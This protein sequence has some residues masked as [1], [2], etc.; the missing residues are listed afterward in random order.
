MEPHAIV[1]A[2]DGDRVEIDTPNQAIAMAQSAFAAFFGIPAQNVT[3]R[4]PFL[5]GGFGSKAILA[6][7]QILAILAARM[8]GRPVKLVLRRDQ[9]FGPVGHRGATRQR[10]RLAL[11]G[12]ARLTALEHAAEATTSSFDAFLE[13]AANA[14][15]NL[16]ASPAIV[17][18]HTGV[19]TDTGTPGPMRAPGEG[20]TLTLSGGNIIGDT[21]TIDGANPQTG[22]ALTDIF[23]SVTNNPDTNVLSGTLADNGGA[24]ATIALNEAASN[25]A[26][27]A[28]DDGLAPATDARGFSR[29]D[30]A[31]AANNGTNVSDLGAFEASHSLVVTTLADAVDATDGLLSLREALA[32][33]QQD[34]TTADTITF[35][36]AL[37]GGMI[38]LTN[39]ELAVDSDVAIDGDTDADNVADITISGNNT[40]RVFAVTG[41]D[42]TFDA[43]TI[44]YGGNTDFGG[45]VAVLSG[46]ALTI[47]NS[48]L[49]D[50]F[51]FNSGGGIANYTGG[52]LT[53]INSTLSSNQSSYDGGAI[54]NNGTAT[55]INTTLSEN[56]AGQ[57]GGGIFNGA[58]ATLTLTNAT[59][60][61]NIAG[62]GD[63]GGIFNDGGAATLTNV[64]LSHNSADH[65]GGIFNDGGTTT[66]TNT[67]LSG[68]L[69]FYAGGG[70]SNNAGTVA[71]TNS[72]VAGKNA[73]FSS[74][75]HDGTLDLTGGN[76]V[77]ETLRSTAISLSPASSR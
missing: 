32:L 57:Y 46:A 66:L 39:G 25:P 11:D 41:G 24:V 19:R 36:A 54:L 10:V 1:A 63:G 5:G 67:T 12:Q 56:Q 73:G 7:P 76:I 49:I 69:G 2:W 50:G 22:I 30:V 62:S 61:G 17:T 75:E 4:S 43:L 45:N 64:T 72:I 34:P 31:G 13:P 74:E 33:A 27:D 42:V 48:T 55:L 18:T 68:N 3:V 35:D 70:I 40:S 52:T 71:L 6:G 47:V 60:S 58:T 16:Y 8:L 28:G 21:R 9:M 23:A 65:G 38:V 20:G 59:L 14:S 29:D 44:I 53:L 37:T 26:L 51:A 15:H 77:G